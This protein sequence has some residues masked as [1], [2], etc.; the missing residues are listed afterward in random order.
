[1]SHRHKQHGL[2]AVSRIDGGHAA[3][4][5]DKHVVLNSLC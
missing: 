2:V 1:M 3:Y 5:A 4:E